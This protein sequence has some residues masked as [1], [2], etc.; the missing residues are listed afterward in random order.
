[1]VLNELMELPSLKM[2]AKNKK[3]KKKKIIIKKLIKL[4]IKKINN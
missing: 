2:D 1:M 4:Y 3:K